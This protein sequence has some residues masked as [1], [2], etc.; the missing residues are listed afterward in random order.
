M[1]DLHEAKAAIVGARAATSTLPVICSLTY[2][3]EMRLLTGADPETAIT[4]LEALGVDVVGVNCGFGPDMMPAILQRQFAI[5]DSFLLVQPNAGLPQ[6]QNGRTVYS[7]SASDFASYVPALVANGANIINGCCGTTPEYMRLVAAQAQR[8]SPRPRS[9]PRFSK[10]AGATET[11]CIGQEWP[12]RVIGERINPTANQRLATALRQRDFKAVADEARAQAAAGADLLD[13]NVGLSAPG[14]QET[15]LMPEAV[16]A[17]QR[18][19]P[20]PLVIDTADSQ[21]MESALRVYRGKPLLNSTSGHAEQLEQMTDLAQKYGAAIVG[22]TLDENGIPDKASARLA[23]AQRI[24]DRALAKGIRRQDIYIDTLTLTVGASQEQL[25]ETLQALR[26]VKEQL[27][28]RTLLGVSNV[29][30][31]M[32]RRAAINSVFLAMALG[33]GLDL[34]I[35]NPD[36]AGVWEIIYAADV[37]TNRDPQAQRYLTKMQEMPAAVS[38]P[39]AASASAPGTSLSSLERLQSDILTGEKGH[40]PQLTQT[41]LDEGWTATDIINQGVIPAMEQ[42]S[43][44][45]DQ[46]IFFLPQLLLAAEAAQETFQILRPELEQKADSSIGTVVIATV[47]GDIHDIGKSIVSLLLQNNNFA[48]VD[49]GKDV[50]CQDIIDAAQQAQADII[51]LSALMTTTMPQMKV[52]VRQPKRGFGDSDYGRRRRSDACICCFH[53]CPL[54]S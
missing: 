52:V 47:A 35:I 29:S 39:V 15:E 28:V 33:A 6:L 40:L 21:V 46:H 20:A 10:L 1:S 3:Q 19:V 48:V 11:V 13:I 43:D 26:W 36:Q 32:P 41:L 14:V 27:G 31:G 50:P 37:L 12:T 38:T 18:A 34:P 22:L 42:A 23:I 25:L 7:L 17:A 54:C 8:L 24:V 51:M 16:M 4:V 9:S 45:Y 5:S 30:H 44:K 49:L 53:R 2:T